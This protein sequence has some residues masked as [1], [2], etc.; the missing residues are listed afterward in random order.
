MGSLILNSLRT[1]RW[2]MRWRWRQCARWLRRPLQ[3]A[4]LWRQSSV[5]SSPGVAGF[6][7]GAFN[8]GF[9]PEPDGTLLLLAKAQFLHWSL[10]LRTNPELFA[11][12][13]PV[14][15]RVANPYARRI[16]SHVVLRWKA[17]EG[18]EGSPEDLRTFRLGATWLVN[19][20]VVHA[21]QA[22]AF[23]AMQVVSE[24]DA[25]NSEL[26]MLGRPQLDFPVRGMEKNWQYYFDDGR[27]AVTGS[28]GLLLIYE[29]SPLR[30][31]VCSDRE[32]W[33]FETVINQPLVAA[34]SD[35][36]GFGSPVSLSTNP[37]VYDDSHLLLLI[38]QVD[39][40]RGYRCYFNW[41]VLLCRSS[42]I[43]THISSSPIFDGR[44]SRGVLPGVVYPTA[45]LMQ[46]DDV[47]VF[48]GE[49]DSHI[50]RHRFTRDQLDAQWW[51]VGQLP[52]AVVEGSSG[53]TRGESPAGPTSRE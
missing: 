8:P 22:G 6:R 18:V 25:T 17:H 39:R 19:H 42:L 33:R 12:G 48:C 46:G 15:L 43:P 53:P 4:Q 23:R 52:P 11:A 30:V 2:A 40:S 1:L 29:F 16:D 5:L 37:V 21:S 44:L 47:L 9:I 49:G 36:G 45:V 26:R 28:T 50:T 24:Y 31:L 41:A 38:H 7:G 35:P 51:A 3:S 27:A 14:G 13:A 34:L 32:Q 20:A 10:A